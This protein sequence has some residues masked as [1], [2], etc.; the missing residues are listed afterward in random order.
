MLDSK[1]S[2]QG[3]ISTKEAASTFMKMHVLPNKDYILNAI[4]GVERGIGIK[5]DDLMTRTTLNKA[6][7]VLIKSLFVNSSSVP[8]DESA[9]SVNW[10]AF[11]TGVFLGTTDEVFAPSFQDYWK[12]ICQRYL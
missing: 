12:K 1:I 7:P 9:N 4:N 5:Q 6:L 3:T 8:D 2:P 11:A 10:L